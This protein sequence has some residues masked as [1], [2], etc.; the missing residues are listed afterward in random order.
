ME[1]RNEAKAMNAASCS[2]WLAYPAFSIAPRDSSH[3][4][5]GSNT[6]TINQENATLA[7]A[8]GQSSQGIF[9]VKVPSF[10]IILSCV[11]LT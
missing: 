2:P 1:A 4:E 8:T 5:L 7:W 6:S 10:Q 11:K 9:L 3:S